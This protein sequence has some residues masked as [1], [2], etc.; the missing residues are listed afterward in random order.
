MRKIL[1]PG[2]KTWTIIFPS[3]LLCCALGFFAC[4]FGDKIEMRYI[5]HLVTVGEIPQ[6]L[7]DFPEE[8]SRCLKEA[9]GAVLFRSPEGHVG[10]R[11][12]GDEL[13]SLVDSLI[14]AIDRSPVSLPCK[15]RPFVSH[16][17]EIRGNGSPLKIS[18]NQHGHLHMKKGDQEYN[19]YL[20]QG[21]IA[22]LTSFFAPLP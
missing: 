2:F 6:L 10:R 13:G 15:C 1:R 5:Q 18:L 8:I 14:V 19:T 21:G 11:L 16:Q 3:T 7:V 12:D 22:T 9:E 17:I 20:S 4:L